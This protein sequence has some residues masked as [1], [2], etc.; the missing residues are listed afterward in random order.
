[1]SEKMPSRTCAKDPDEGLDWIDC[2]ICDGKGGFARPEH[3]RCDI[4]GGS[5][6]IWALARPA[7]K[8]V[9]VAAASAL[10]MMEGH[11]DTELSKDGRALRK[12]A[13]KFCASL[14]QDGSSPKPQ[15]AG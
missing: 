1:M 2:P 12:A 7:L 15:G 14:P 11:P 8:I 5:G 3:E 13:R 10:I 6:V 4:C 9:E